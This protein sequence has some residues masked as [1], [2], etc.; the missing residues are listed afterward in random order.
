[1]LQRP[2][3]STTSTTRTRRSALPALTSL[4][5]FAAFGI[6]LFHSRGYF[7]IPKDAE[8]VFWGEQPVSF[9]FVLSGFILYYSYQSLNGIEGATN[10]AGRASPGSGRCMP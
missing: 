2:A 10:S 1:M 9:F 7:G 4:R 5:F 8:W 3:M 6:V